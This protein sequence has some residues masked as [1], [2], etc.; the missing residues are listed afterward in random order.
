MELLELLELLEKMSTEVNKETMDRLECLNPTVMD[1]LTP[2]DLELK[3]MVE[4]ALSDFPKDE[5]DGSLQELEELAR[6]CRE[7]ARTHSRYRIRFECVS[8]LR[9]F[10]WMAAFVTTNGSKRQKLGP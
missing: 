1:A 7:L 3:A 8:L 5:S 6:S 4:K 2:D 10:T 9:R